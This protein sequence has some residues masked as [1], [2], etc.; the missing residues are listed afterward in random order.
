MGMTTLTEVEY[1]DEPCDGLGS[2][3]TA[4]SRSPQLGQSHGYVGDGCQGDSVIGSFR[5]R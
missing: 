3:T 5:V 2:I 4:L 1:V